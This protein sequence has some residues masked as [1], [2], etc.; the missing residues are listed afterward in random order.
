LKTYSGK[1]KVKNRK[2]YEGNASDVVYRSSWERYCFVWCDSSKHVLRWSSEEVVV[3]YLYEVDN[4]VHRYY[5]DLKIVTESKTLLIEIKPKAQTSPP[6]GSRRTKRYISEALTYVKNRNK[7]EAAD[8]FAKKKG[9]EFHIWTEDELQSKGIMP[10]AI[11]K[12]KTKKKF[13]P[14]GPVKSKKRYK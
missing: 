10:K 11:T 13:K 1:Y 6:K 8:A 9:W 2:K 14:F 7:W 4:K 5:L 12:M 3:P